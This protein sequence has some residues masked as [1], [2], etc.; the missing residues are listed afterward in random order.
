[1]RSRLTTLIP[2]VLCAIAAAY[3]LAHRPRTAERYFLAVLHDTGGAEIEPPPGPAT[4]LGDLPA[5]FDSTV[6]ALDASGHV[7]VDGTAPRRVGID[8]SR[9]LDDLFR[10]KNVDVKRTWLVADRRVAWAD[11]GVLLAQLREAGA[12]TAEL[13]VR[14]PAEGGRITGPRF[15]ARRIPIDLFADWEPARLGADDLVVY[16]GPEDP[17]TEWRRGDVALASEVGAA[18]GGQVD[19]DRLAERVALER[20]RHPALRVRLFIERRTSLERAL[21]AIALAGRGAASPDGFRVVLERPSRRVD[22]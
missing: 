13:L 14:A 16:V 19:L 8:S 21:A 4:S 11:L 15:G 3:W 2:L 5:G 12:H 22:M 1:M 17:N 18:E 20:R 10:L 7:A 6:I 9:G